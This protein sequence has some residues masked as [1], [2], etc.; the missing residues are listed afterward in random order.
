MQATAGGSLGCPA[1]GSVRQLRSRMPDAVGEQR[2]SAEVHEELVAQQ[3]ALRLREAG[4]ISRG[5]MPQ[6]YH[7]AAAE[8]PFGQNLKRNV[9]PNEVEI[10][11][12]MPIAHPAS[13]SALVSCNWTTTSAS[14]VE[15]DVC[16]ASRAPRPLPGSA[17]ST[18]NSAISFPRRRHNRPSPLPSAVPASPNLPSSRSASCRMHDY[19]ENVHQR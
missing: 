13:R 3:G 6:L 15:A 9:T 16:E 12:V 17:A 14:K 4:H 18:A 10:R 7:I 1:W 5:V 11:Y 8:M 2:H 19:T